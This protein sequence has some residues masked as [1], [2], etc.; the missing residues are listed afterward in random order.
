MRYVL[1]VK[2]DASFS[3]RVI[4]QRFFKSKEFA[5]ARRNADRILRELSL[6]KNLKET[7]LTTNYPT[8]EIRNLFSC[9][10]IKQFFFVD[11]EVK[12][13]N[14]DSGP[15][16][17]LKCELY[18]AYHDY[19]DLKLTLETV[20][21]ADLATAIKR[22]EYDTKTKINPPPSVFE[23]ETIIKK[24]YE[25]KIELEKSMERIDKDIQEFLLL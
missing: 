9:S 2:D 3:K 5:L 25:I 11:K 10:A 17:I 4:T 12:K 6:I 21:K 20:A 23:A 16:Q 7:H 8:W 1:K 24:L 22:I 19:Q 18:P 15:T 14:P 13:Q